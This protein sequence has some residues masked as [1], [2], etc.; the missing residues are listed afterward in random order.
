MKAN[1]PPPNGQRPVS[2]RP[3]MSLYQASERSRSVTWMPTCPTR[4]IVNPFAMLPSPLRVVV[5]AN[6]K[7]L[8]DFRDDGGNVVFLI[9]KV[10]CGRV[11]ACVDRVSQ[12][13]LFVVGPELA[14]AR[15]G[16]DDR[17]H[18]LAVLAL[19][20]ADENV[21]HNVAVLIKFDWP[22]RGVGD[23]D[24]MQGLG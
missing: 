9:L 21:A 1:S 18:Q 22:A 12:E 6:T 14:H 13:C 8:C 11:V 17:V 10:L 19:A 5:R 16:L 23:R 3:R 7:A 4:L 2:V 15:I 20:A 24:L